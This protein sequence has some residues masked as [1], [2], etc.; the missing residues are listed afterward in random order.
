[1][2]VCLRPTLVLMRLC[3]LVLKSTDALQASRYW[4]VRKKISLY[5]GAVWLKQVVFELKDGSEK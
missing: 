2:I 4:P 1:M 5:K 3:T